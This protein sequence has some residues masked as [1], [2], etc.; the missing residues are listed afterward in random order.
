MINGSPIAWWSK[1]QTMIAQS[2]CEAEYAALTSLVIA[3]RW[4]RP[5][6][7]E[8]FKVAPSPI[9]TEIDKTA[10]MITANTKKITARNRHFLMKES[11]IREAI[12]DGIITL[13]FTPID[14]CK[15][16]GLTK[17]LQRVIISIK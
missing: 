14:K 17:A 16:D 4:I 7:E 2:T 8:L 10:A 3:A 15:A 6:Y 1:K 5:L 13:E 12:K 9:K 11:T